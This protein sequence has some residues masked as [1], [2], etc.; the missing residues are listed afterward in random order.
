MKDVKD[1]TACVVD[2]GLFLP[3]ALRLAEE[4]KRVLYWS[5]DMRS[6]PSMKQGVIGDGFSSIERVREFWP[7]HN[8]IDLWV[9]PDV[10]QPGLQKHLVEDGHPV[11]GSGDGEVLEMNR[12]K[13]MKVLG[14][15]GLDVAEFKVCVGLGELSDYLHENED[16]YVKV[17]RWRGD[18]ETTHWRNWAMDCGWLDWLA[19]SLGPLKD[20]MRFLV[21]PAIDT[22]LEIGGDTYCVDGN[23]PS[24]MLNGLEHKD[25]TYFSAVTK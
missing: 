20:H 23:W 15:V 14:E 8:E 25:T 1:I 6:F 10:G 22:T 19:Y 13:F 5:P 11:W 3:M 17:S 9:F 16:Q 24:T 12:E 7:H 18:L 4:Y 2:S 21:F